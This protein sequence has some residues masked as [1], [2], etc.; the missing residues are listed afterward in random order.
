METHNT[1]HIL[2]LKRKMSDPDIH[3]PP[4]DSHSPPTTTRSAAISIPHRT[5]DISE[6]NGEINGMYLKDTYQSQI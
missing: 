2:K 6:S 1:V 3:H 4:P 5:D